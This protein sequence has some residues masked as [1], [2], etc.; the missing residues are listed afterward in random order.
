VEG[1]GKR[2]VKSF[3]KIGGP[4]SDRKGCRKGC[5]QARRARR[6]Q[7]RARHSVRRSRGRTP[8][9]PRLQGFPSK[10]EPSRQAQEGHPHRPGTQTPRPTEREGTRCTIPDRH[11]CL[12]SQ[13][14]AH[15]DLLPLKGEK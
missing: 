4:G 1:D 2:D 3:V 15:P 12:T 5:R 10:V 13:T 7:K 8:P 11:P 14:V 9:R 6:P